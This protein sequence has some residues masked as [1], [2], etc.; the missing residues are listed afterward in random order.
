MENTNQANCVVD[1]GEAALFPEGKDAVAKIIDIEPHKRSIRVIFAIESMAGSVRIP[2]RPLVDYFGLSG[3]G[4][5]LLGE[6]TRAASNRVSDADVDLKELIG[7]QVVLQIKHERSEG[8]SW[9]SERAINFR[10]ISTIT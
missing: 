3:R 4:L 1:F 9:V 5:H 2:D 10:S 7:K 6:L 8:D